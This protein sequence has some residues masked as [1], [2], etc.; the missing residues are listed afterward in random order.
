LL[1]VTVVGKMSTLEMVFRLPLMLDG[2]FT[3]LSSVH[4]FRTKEL[5]IRSEPGIWLEADGEVLGC[6]PARVTC[7]QEAIWVVVP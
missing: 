2:S 6:T 5:R 7:L 3:R 1:D 4:T